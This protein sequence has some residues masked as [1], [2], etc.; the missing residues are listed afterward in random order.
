[1]QAARRSGIF[2]MQARE[3]NSSREPGCNE[4]CL[5]GVDIVSKAEAHRH[6]RENGFDPSATRHAIFN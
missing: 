1:M 4:E 6:L 5:R 3:E 2:E